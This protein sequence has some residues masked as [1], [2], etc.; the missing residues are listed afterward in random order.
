MHGSVYG[1]I[2]ASSL[3]GMFAGWLVDW[4]Y[5][6]SCAS[7]SFLSTSSCFQN[8]GNSQVTL[9]LICY[10]LFSWGKKCDWFQTLLAVPLNILCGFGHFLFSLNPYFLI[11]LFGGRELDQMMCEGPFSTKFYMMILADGWWHIFIWNIISYYFTLLN[12]LFL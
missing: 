3:V 10:S 12:Y 7:A 9:F 5:F 6:L 4:F 11:F 1:W 2:M 8:Y